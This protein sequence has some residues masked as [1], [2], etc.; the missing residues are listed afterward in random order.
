MPLKILTQ[1]SDGS[2]NSEFMSI[3]KFGAESGRLF[4]IDRVGGSA[5]FENVPTEILPGARMVFDFGSIAE[6]WVLLVAGQAPSLALVPAGQALPQ[7]PSQEHRQGVRV[8]IHLGQQGGV[9]EFMS[10]S[11]SVT[12]A[13]ADLYMQFEAA[14]EA[15]TGKV[16]IVDFQGSTMHVQKNSY[17]TRQLYTPRLVITGWIER[18]GEFG[19]RTVPPP[20]VAA[21]AA[22]ARVTAARTPA[23]PPPP[24]PQAMPTPAEPWGQPARAA[25]GGKAK[26]QWGGEGSDLESEIPF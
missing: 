18:L 21:P 6:G 8:I 19:E 22:A 11:K 20:G 26:D 9:R 2:G 10:A 5:G 14:P 1:M 17:G 7:R 15:A 25:G 12:G 23:P 13:I 24:P 3:V 4:R 16:P